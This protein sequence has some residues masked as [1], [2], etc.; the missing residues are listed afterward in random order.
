MLEATLM[1]L[2]KEPLPGRAKT[3]LCPPC[4]PE[5][6]ARLATAALRDTLEVV[7][8][9]P[10]RRRVLV[11]AGDGERWCPP[12]FA[13]IVQRGDGLAERLAAAFEDVSQPALLVGMDTPQLTAALLSDGL[14]ALSRPGVDAV[15]GPALDGGYWSVGLKRAQPGVFD[16]V[17]MSRPDTCAVQRRRLRQLGLRVHEQPRLRDVDTM[18]DARLVAHD[19]PGS[20]LA[21]A[22]ASL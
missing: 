3:R 6:A 11:F 16:G 18:S 14:G 5:Q 10:A 1:V 2:A 17:P 15:L 21:A 13:L 8:R 7:A 9:T 4:D 19:A 20:H 12:G 22:L